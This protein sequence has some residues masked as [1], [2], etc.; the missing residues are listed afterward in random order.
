M[1]TRRV[2]A[3]AVVCVWTLMASVAAAGT[4]ESTG[5][6][7]LGPEFRVTDRAET[8]YMSPAVA[9]DASS[10][11]FLVVWSQMRWL[12]PRD[13]EDDI[14]GQRFAADGTRIGLNFWISGRAA[15]HNQDTPAVVFNPTEGEYLVVW[16]DSRNY[17]W[18]IRGHDIYG[19]RLTADGARIGPNF[20]ISRGHPTRSDVWPTVAYNSVRNEYLVVW[21]TYGSWRIIGQRLAGDGTRIGA[22]FQINGGA[23]DDSRYAKLAYNSSDDEYLVV[24]QDERN[25]ATRRWDIYGQRLTGDGT[26]IGANFRISGGAATA[27]EFH[28]TVTYNSTDNQYLVVWQDRRDD[29]TW[30]NGDDVYGQLLTADGIRIR[31]NFL[32]STGTDHTKN[33]QPAVVHNPTSNQYLVVWSDERNRDHRGFDLFARRL[34]ADGS[35]IGANFRICSDGAT[36]NEWWPAVIYDP[37]H[38]Q[39]LVV[40]EDRRHAQSWYNDE[41]IYGR[42]IAALWPSSG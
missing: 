5:I 28:P 1:A 30:V 37:G 4:G 2:V 10:G 36:G 8:N 25:Q 35:R 16:K 40:W 9:V 34:T 32:I 15:D 7:F 3:G 38:A 14:R 23:S 24:W 20:Q 42:R 13:R 27:Q 18:G 39:H 31:G 22:Y 21:H 12:G 19:Q 41:E 26:R 11:E 17:H 33:V 29:P 6:P